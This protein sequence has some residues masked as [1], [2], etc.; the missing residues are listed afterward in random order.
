M[1]M[2][3]KASASSRG[4]P[5]QTEQARQHLKTMASSYFMS[6][7]CVSMCMAAVCTCAY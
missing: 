3:D 1:S 7:V 2:V 5:N 4:K 6:Y